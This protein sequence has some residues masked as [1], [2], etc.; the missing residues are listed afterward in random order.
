MNRSNHNQ[1]G[2]LSLLAEPKLGRCGYCEDRCDATTSFHGYCLD[3]HQATLGM[4]AGTC[5]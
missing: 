2:N 3:L 5:G 4:N 1:G